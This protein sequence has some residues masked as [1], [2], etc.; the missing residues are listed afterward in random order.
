MFKNIMLVGF[1]SFFGGVVR[2]LVT[3]MLG[4]W[5]FLPTLLAR[6]P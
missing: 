1:G 2:Y 6:L 4:L 5:W 3:R